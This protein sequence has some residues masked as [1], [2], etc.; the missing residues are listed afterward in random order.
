MPT[1]IY[2]PPRLQ[3]P[4]EVAS[5]SDISLPDGTPWVS[6][7]QIG[8]VYLI[9]FPKLADFEIFNKGTDISIH[10]VPGGSTDTLEHL[11]H[12][13]ALPLALSLQKKLVLHGSAVEIGDRA[14][15]FVAESGRGKSTL[16]ASFAAR[17]FRFL[18]DDAL[19]VNVDDDQF[20]IQPSHPS[21]R[22]WTDSYN[23]IDPASTRE[24]EAIG[25]NDK[26]RLLADE[27]FRYCSE[28]C[29]LGVVYFLGDGSS[30]EIS[31]SPVLGHQSIIETLRHCFFLGVNQ[32]E[33]LANNFQQLV[34]LSKQLVFFKLDYPRRFQE[35]DLVYKAILDHVHQQSCGTGF[36]P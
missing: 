10:P 24:T 18:A 25:Y 28:S 14:V 13:Q 36:A 5:F 12:N 20:E 6:L 34:T 35:L 15:A 11:Y 21:I 17:G 26:L 4:L 22:L 2:R 29:S 32:R 16:A 9:R 19:I 23:A 27:S 31:I 7:F 30:K 1:V 8:H 3:L 33:L